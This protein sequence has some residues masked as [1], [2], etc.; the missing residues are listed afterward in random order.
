MLTQKSTMIGRGSLIASAR[1]C[2]SRAI[3]KNLEEIFDCQIDENGLKSVS[4]AINQ[5]PAKAEVS[6]TELGLP[7]M[8]LRR[9]KPKDPN[10]PK[11]VKP[12][13]KAESEEIAALLQERLV[14]TLATT[15][16]TNEVFAD[17][18]SK[19]SQ[20]T[21]IGSYLNFSL[22]P[23]FLGSI[24]D[25]IVS[26]DFVKPM[27]QTQPKVMVE[28]SQPNTHKAFHVGHMRNV[29]LGDAVSRIYSMLGFQVGY[30]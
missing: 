25:D 8:S 13:V 6:A 30:V 11:G 18:R 14:K 1:E 16:C 15:D 17:F 7:T 28:F 19:V 9:F 24:V 12:N 4:S 29:A 26:G 27:P 5:P 2:L 10:A 23:S 21:A 20:V 3:C 22:R